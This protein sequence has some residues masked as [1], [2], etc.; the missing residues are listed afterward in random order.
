MTDPDPLVL[1]LQIEDE[2]FARFDDLRR[3]HFPKALNRVPAHVTLFHQLPG[4]EE[5]GVT[6]RIE[7]LARGQLAPEVA[8]TGLRMTGRGVA[9]VLKSEALSAFRDSLARGFAPWLTPQDRAPW[10]PHLTVQNKVEPEVARDL[11][12]ALGKDFSPF[13]FPAPGV[14]L[15]RYRNGPWEPR[16]ALLFGGNE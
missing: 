12:A 13:R 11:H 14:L 6:H 1:T 3:R 16:A 10:Q 9:F 15:W 7:T 4:A 2:A 5:E 8:V